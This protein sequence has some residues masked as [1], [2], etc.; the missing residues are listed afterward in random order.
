MLS[1]VDERFLD[2]RRTFVRLWP[3]V[4][5]GMALLTVGFWGY[6]LLRRPL[7]ANPFHLMHAL[8]RHAV[9]GATLVILALVGSLMVLVT[10]VLLL[11]FVALAFA[12]IANERRL[13]AMIDRLQ[14]R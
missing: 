3:A 6:L 4:G 14:R 1:A 9:S 5:T 7:L 8:E 13:L 12:A 10:G 11:V 2:R